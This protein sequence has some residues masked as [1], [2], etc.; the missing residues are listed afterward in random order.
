MNFLF[1][2]PFGVP[3]NSLPIDLKTLCLPPPPTFTPPPSVFTL[4]INEVENVDYGT[5]QVTE[6][7]RLKFYPTK[8]VQRNAMIYNAEA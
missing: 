4:T 1:V 6:V 5:D 7:S 3:S 2:N 8:Q